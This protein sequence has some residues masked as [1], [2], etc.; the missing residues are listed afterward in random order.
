[1]AR[2][3][4]R[5]GAGRPPKHAAEM[6]R[7]KAAKTLSRCQE[8]I[9]ARLPE[10]I[11]RMIVEALDGDRASLKFLVEMGMGKA[12]V[13]QQAVPDTEIKV[14]LGNIPRPKRGSEEDA[15][16]RVQDDGDGE[17]AGGS[18]AGA[19]DDDSAAEGDSD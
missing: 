1:M 16:L 18:L 4:A 17:A 7:D 10:L 9:Q 6:K 14:V 3:G 19:G 15:T 13:K 11:D 12:P 5:P 8:T 2:G